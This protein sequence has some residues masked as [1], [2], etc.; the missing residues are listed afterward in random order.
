LI[1]INKDKIIYIILFIAGAISLYSLFY[2]IDNKIY[3]IGSDAYYYWSVADSIA[4]TGRYLD[5][6][7]IPYEPIRT[8]Q[9]GIIFFHQLFG[10]MGINGESRFVVI[11]YFYYLLHLSAI[12]PINQIAKK[13]GLSDL[14]P[15]VLIIAAYLGAWHIYET[16]LKLDNEGFFN[17]LSIWFIYLL[18]LLYQDIADLKIASY[19][20]V[21]NKNSW[22]IIIIG[23]LSYILILFRLQILLIH[24][25]AIFTAIVLKKWKVLRWNISFLFISCISLVSYLNH[26]ENTRIYSTV[27]MQSSK[28]MLEFFSEIYITIFDILPA[29]LYN[30]DLGNW[31]DYIVI[32]V[33]LIIVWMFF[34]S[35]RQKD[36]NLLFFTT[37]CGSALLWITIFGYSRPRYIL[38]IYSFIFLIIFIKPKMRLIGFFFVFLVLTSSTYKLIRPYVRPPASKIT[39]YLIE[40][41]ISLPSK[42]PLLLSTF[43][44]HPY[45]FLNSSTFQGDL[46]FDKILDKQEIF[47]LADEKYLSDKIAII[48]NLAD[49]NSYTFESVSLIPDYD[50]S[51]TEKRFSIQELLGIKMGKQQYRR[52]GYDLI[53]LYNFIKK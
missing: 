5:T 43:E 31:V 17:S 18:V 27:E 7:I 40:N 48:K 49:S 25:S 39:L 33:V 32:P 12:Y 36:Q 13:I 47:I 4:K 15:R 19:F 34:Q 45:F 46:T 44:R 28:I 10:N 1:T 26:V 50:E 3:F 20:S 2:F 30:Y 53:H 9:I 22:I 8:T 14:L 11:A 35:I 6:T 42:D 52:S 51:I 37:L 24:F 21:K 41:K 16:Q 38:Y 29:V 23:L